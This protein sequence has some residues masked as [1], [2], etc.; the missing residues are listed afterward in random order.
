M[1]EQTWYEL[2][3]L[4]QEIRMDHAVTEDE[5]CADPECDCIQQK[6]LRCLKILET[7]A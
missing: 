6:A 7:R 1:T 3:A 5:V 2:C 4:L